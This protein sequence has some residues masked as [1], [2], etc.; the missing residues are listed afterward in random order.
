MYY[1]LNQRFFI[2]IVDDVLLLYLILSLKIF[3]LKKNKNVSLL[4]FIY[5]ILRI[6]FI[7]IN[8]NSFLPTMKYL[9]HL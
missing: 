6:T 5:Y 8:F 4:Y 2:F 3:Y 7:I 9:I 1:L